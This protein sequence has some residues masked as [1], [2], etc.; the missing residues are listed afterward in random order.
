MDEVLIATATARRQRFMICWQGNAFQVVML[1][2]HHDLR[3]I[4][5]SIGDLEQPLFSGRNSRLCVRQH[6]HSIVIPLKARSTRSI[7]NRLDK[8]FLGTIFAEAVD[9]P[10]FSR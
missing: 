1:P 2:D 10:L 4:A 5:W 9:C 3:R 6:R 8:R 7:R